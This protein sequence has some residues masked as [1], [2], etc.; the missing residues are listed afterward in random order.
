MNV[1]RKSVIKTKHDHRGW[2]FEQNIV[3]KGSKFEKLNNMRVIQKV[4]VLKKFLKIR[5]KL[6]FAILKSFNA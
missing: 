3:S 4:S 5:L 6:L 1:L 2:W